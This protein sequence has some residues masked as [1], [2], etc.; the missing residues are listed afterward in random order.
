MHIQKHLGV[1][2]GGNEVIWISNIIPFCS[3][4]NSVFKKSIQEKGRLCFMSE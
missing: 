3:T 1:F 4:Q 2:T